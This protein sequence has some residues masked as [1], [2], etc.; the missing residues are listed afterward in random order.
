[1]LLLYSFHLFTDNRFICHVVALFL[2]YHLTRWISFITK[3]EICVLR[4]LTTLQLNWPPV[5]LKSITA[6]LLTPIILCV[7]GGMC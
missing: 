5:R 3:L 2:H 1:M 4:V 7:F 6:L